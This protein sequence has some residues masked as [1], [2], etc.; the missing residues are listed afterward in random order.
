MTDRLYYTD[1]YLTEFDA[2]VLR[3]A[4]MPDGRTAAVLD[5]TAFYPTS[6][7][8]PF[9]TGTLGS[10]R[11]VDVV[12][13]DDG[14][15]LH[16]VE[17]SVGTGPVRGRVD[18]KRRFEH[19]QQ[20]TGQHVLSAAFEN[21]AHSGTISFHLGSDASTIDLARDVSAREIEAAEDEANRI[22]WEDRDVTVSFADAAAAA[23]LP[24]RKEPAREGELRVIEI[25]GYDW[26]ACGGTHVARTGAIGIIA[27]GSADRIRGGSRIEFFCGVRA[28]ASHR[29]LR[30]IVAAGSKALSAAAADLPAAIDRLQL[31]LKDLRRQSKDFQGKLA[32]HEADVLTASAEPGARGQAVVAALEGWDGAGLKQIASAIVA[33]PGFI[34]VLISSPA[35]SSIVVARSAGVVFDASGLLKVLIARF[36]GKGGGRP[37]LAQ[38]GGL[39]GVAGDV[40]AMARSAIRTP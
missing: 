20:H 1:A 32:S 31:D 24:L 6:G 22:V 8:Q 7:G 27:V 25:A 16:V 15:V 2:E 36:G 17:G 39:N 29:R 21:T 3:V 14:T 35:P 38:G 13:Q 12:D 23:R 5:R 33:R 18:W 30:D 9:D 28:L 10:A 37:E 34:A 40:L 19:M 26:S 4:P 11:V